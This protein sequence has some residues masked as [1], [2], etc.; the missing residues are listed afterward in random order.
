MSVLTTND[1]VKEAKLTMRKAG[2]GQVDFFTILLKEARVHSIDIDCDEH[3][4]A[5]ER[6]SF[7]F[8]VVQV[9]YLPQLA[10]G[11]RG[12]GSQFQDDITPAT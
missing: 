4:N 1:E 7:A 3:G 11:Q 6:V 5:V 12:G 2:E 9:D 8:N 10:S